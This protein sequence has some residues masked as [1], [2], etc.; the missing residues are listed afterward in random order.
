MPVNKELFPDFPY[1]AIEVV[2]FIQS[3]ELFT[4]MLRNGRVIHFCPGDAA[5]FRSWL[6]EN[7]VKAV[8][9]I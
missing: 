7:G 1:R 4:C 9:L 2:R 8:P 5:L 3:K 6:L